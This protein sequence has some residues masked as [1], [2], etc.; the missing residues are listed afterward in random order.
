MMIPVKVSFKNISQSNH[1]ERELVSALAFQENS[2]EDNILIWL[3]NAGL[4]IDSFQ[5]G[6]VS[7]TRENK[8]LFNSNEI[9]PYEKIKVEFN[10]YSD[11]EN[12]FSPNDFFFNPFTVNHNPKLS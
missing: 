3:L 8:P 2:I 12:K 7:V 9:I 11:Y 10:P 6:L 4:P 1:N 5:D